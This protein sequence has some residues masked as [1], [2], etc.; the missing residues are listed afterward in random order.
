[1]SFILSGGILTNQKNHSFKN[2]HLLLSIVNRDFYWLSKNLYDVCDLYSSFFVSVFWSRN[3]FFLSYSNQFK[4]NFAL[5]IIV[6]L[7]LKSILYNRRVHQ[8]R[9]TLKH[10]CDK[11]KLKFFNEYTHTTL[12][13]K[14]KH[15]MTIDE[16]GNNNELFVFLCRL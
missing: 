3:V 6:I 16:T 13:T 1:M 14:C 2:L 8:I 15:N 10:S 11:T 9:N 5:I 12:L 4:Y 7:K